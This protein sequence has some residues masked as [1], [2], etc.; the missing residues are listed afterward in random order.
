MVLNDRQIGFFVSKVLHL[1]Q[2]KRKEYIE[3]VN[4]LITEL[5]KKIT[6]D[7]SFKVKGFKKPVH[8]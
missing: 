6:G 7:S 1:G 4:N 8:S 3:Q 2:G 5:T